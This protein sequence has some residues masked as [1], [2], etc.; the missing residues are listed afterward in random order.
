MLL[1]TCEFSSEFSFPWQYLER[2]SA[3]W[4]SRVREAQSLEQLYF[5]L[6]Q[7]TEDSLRGRRSSSVPSRKFSQ[8]PNFLICLGTVVTLK[9]HK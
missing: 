9:F 5:C 8:S 2:P 4:A 6:T 1:L 3:R 7:A